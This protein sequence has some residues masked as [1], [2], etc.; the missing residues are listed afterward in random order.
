MDLAI[1]ISDLIWNG[2]LFIASDW[3]WIKL[4]MH[5]VMCIVKSNQWIIYVF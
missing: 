1:V 3:I 2:V 4:Y 5:L